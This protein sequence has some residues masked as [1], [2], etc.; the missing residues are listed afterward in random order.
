MKKDI[1]ELR[2]QISERINKING[3]KS[4]EFILANPSESRNIEVVF[5]ISKDYE[6]FIVSDMQ[7]YISETKEENKEIIL[8]KNIVNEEAVIKYYDYYGMSLEIYF[9]EYRMETKEEVDSRILIDFNKD[10]YISKDDIAIE[11]SE[12]KV[13]VSF[14]DISEEYTVTHPNFIRAME[15]KRISEKLVFLESIRFDFLD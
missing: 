8:D 10:N 9:T 2:E 11:Y 4:K 13:K 3:E 14:E 5:D 6:E 15:T 1:F 7:K 12:N